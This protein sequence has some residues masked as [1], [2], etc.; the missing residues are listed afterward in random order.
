MSCPIVLQILSTLICLQ[1]KI[2]QER[3]AQLLQR[4]FLNRPVLHITITSMLICQRV[5]K[6]VQQYNERIFTEW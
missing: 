2:S 1:M 5:A 4:L 3:F 6:E